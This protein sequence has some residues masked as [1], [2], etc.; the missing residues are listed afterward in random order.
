MTL[1]VPSPIDLRVMSDARPWAE[2]ALAKRPVRQEFFDA[3]AQEMGRDG[4][5]VLELG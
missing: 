3:F 5:R 1:D 4:L 2:A